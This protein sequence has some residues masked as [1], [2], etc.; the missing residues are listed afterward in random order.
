MRFLLLNQFYPPDP[1]PT[2]QYLH[3]LAQVLVGRGHEVSVICSRKSYDGRQVY[4][5]REML[6][7]V[8]VC[9]LWA[10]GFG[11]RSFAGKLADYT[12]FYIGLAL[13]L[14]ARSKKL[15][16]IVSLT[17][18]P[19]LGVVGKIASKRLGCGHALWVMDLYPDVIS[20]HKPTQ[21]HNV[22]FKV[23]MSLARFQQRGSAVTV[24]LGPTMSERLTRYADDE[25]TRQRVKWLPLWSDPGLTPW[26]TGDVIPLRVERGWNQEKLVLL[27]S[28]NMG[29]GHR[30]TEFL[31]TAR[32]LGSDGPRW[33]F[34]G[35]GKRR[36]EVESFAR[37][38]PSARLEMLDYAPKARLREHLVSADVHLMSL[39]AGWQGLMVP[40]KLQAS[41]AVGK[42][43]LYV[44]G[45]ESETAKWIEE[46]G[47]GW[48][49]GQNDLAGLLAALRQA[50][51]PGERE[52]RGESARVY[53]LRHFAKT[54]I[55]AEFAQWLES[56]GQKVTPSRAAGNP[57]SSPPI[58]GEMGAAWESGR[59]RH[60]SR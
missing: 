45:R 60:V 40:S 57:A 1:A 38:N 19:Y 21:R 28:G 14:L 44:G 47:G 11:R 30:F 36:A 7:G 5:Q 29:L 25:Q 51:D 32:R 41:F 34:C 27:Y 17:T 56:V 31:E 23:L 42:P 22:L 33:V 48:V 46:S 55:S 6:N 37:Q 20:A 49:V 53:A 8:E 52:R 18:P 24:A 59:P 43:V 12:S 2:G 26:P 4:P 35:G 13:V 39:D 16:L 3:D 54:T 50:E 15:D 10:T 58:V 9:R